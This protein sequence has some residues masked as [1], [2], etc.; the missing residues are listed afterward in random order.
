MRSELDL[1]ISP[2]ILPF[3][4]SFQAFGEALVV[5]GGGEQKAHFV[6][7]SAAF[8]RLLRGGLSG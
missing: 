6:H 2:V 8:R 3:E 7:G 4:S 1:S 5:I